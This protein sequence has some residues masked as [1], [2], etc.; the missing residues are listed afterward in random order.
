MKSN[1]LKTS[2]GSF[3]KILTEEIGLELSYLRREKGFSGNDLAKKL[4]I[5]QQQISRYER[6]VCSINCGMLFSILFYLEINPS[7]FF[8]S[9]VLKI[10]EEYPNAISYIHANESISAA[11]NNYDYIFN[12]QSDVI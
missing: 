3:Q 1:K 6:G 7:L 2:I 9:I 12:R 11:K 8:E 5:S 4:K 10:N